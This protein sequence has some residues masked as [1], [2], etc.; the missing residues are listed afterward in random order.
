MGFILKSA[1]ITRAVVRA[2]SVILGLGTTMYFHVLWC[3]R[4]YYALKSCLIG[5]LLML[6]VKFYQ[7]HAKNCCDICHPL[8]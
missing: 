3:F 8:P 7:L 2:I 5:G 1:G 4:M 6:S